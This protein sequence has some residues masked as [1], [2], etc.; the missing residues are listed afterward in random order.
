MLRGLKCSPS[1][2]GR[3][4]ANANH[5]RPGT[6]DY[7]SPMTHLKLAC[8]SYPTNL[9]DFLVETETFPETLSRHSRSNFSQV[10]REPGP[11]A[12][13]AEIQPLFDGTDRTQAMSKAGNG[14]EVKGNM[15]HKTKGK[16][17]DQGPGAQAKKRRRATPEGPS[18][19]RKALDFNWKR[20]SRNRRSGSKAYA[21][22]YL[23]RSRVF[24]RQGN[25]APLGLLGLTRRETEVLTW[26]TQ[27]KT[28]YEIGVI[29]NISPRTICKHVQRILNKLKVENRTAAAAIAIGT[30]ADAPR[31]FVDML[32][33]SMRSPSIPGRLAANANHPR[34]RTT[35][36]GSP[37]ADQSKRAKQRDPE[38]IRG[39]TLLELLIVVGIIG[40]LLVL[41]APA[42]TTIKGGT[43]VTSAAYTIK[44]VLDTARTYAKANN[45]YTW[46]GFCE[47]DV[48]STTSGCGGTGR[49]VMSIVASKDGTN[50]ATGGAM[51]SANLMQVGK[52]TKVENLH[53]VAFTDGSGQAPADTFATRPPVTFNG[54]QYSLAGTGM[55]ST[56]PFTYPAGSPYTF[57]RTVQFSPR[58]EAVIGNSAQN[59]PQTGAEIGVQPTHG[60]TPDSTNP[61]AIQ[62]TG[63]GGNVKIYRR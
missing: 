16:K 14:N 56:T 25:A 49:I 24:N 58:G 41:I 27:G 4:A 59:S 52:L 5:P 33:G 62:F 17:K 12:D 42:F 3:V 57:S 10:L 51:S 1:I 53:L 37:I 9:F 6:A 54:T 21:S 40:L 2:P 43:D 15:D 39:F 60:A 38:S 47:E 29:L 26:I 28:N 32:R 63:L 11:E 46:V 23:D 61:V 20:R 36:H 22:S 8:S 48:S 35:D 30:L 44:G 18:E 45:T 34:P 19:W 55:N 13:D 50:I 31:G 7:G